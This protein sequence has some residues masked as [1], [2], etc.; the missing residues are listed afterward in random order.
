MPKI[1]AQT[2]TPTKHLSRQIMTNDMTTAIPTPAKMYS[3][4]FWMSE[5]VEPKTPW[6]KVDEMLEETAERA[7]DKTTVLGRQT[8]DKVVDD[9]YPTTSETDDGVTLKLPFAYT[10]IW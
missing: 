5:T 8:L 10:T 4:L 9:S 3:Q 6:L 7:F 1:E 2:I